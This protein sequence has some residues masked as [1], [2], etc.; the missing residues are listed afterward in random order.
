MKEEFVVQMS[1]KCKKVYIP[2]GYCCVFL[3]NQGKDHLEMSNVGDDVCIENLSDD[4]PC[5]KTTVLESLNSFNPEKVKKE[6]V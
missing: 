4:L 1:N 6:N 3:Q 5:Q 2:R